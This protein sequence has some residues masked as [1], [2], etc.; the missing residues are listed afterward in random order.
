M[1]TAYTGTHNMAD[2]DPMA[3]LN[4]QRSK[5]AAMQ[6]AAAEQAQ[7]IISERTKEFFMW[8]RSLDSVDLIR[9]YRN[10]VQTTKA[11]LVDRALS[12]LNTGKSA[13]KVILELAN[14]L[15]NRLMHAPTRAI[16]DAAKKGE[17]AQ[18]N[19]LKKM[20]GIDQE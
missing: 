9:H 1:Y 6:Q 8:L 10:D 13:E 16:Q 19:Q 4:A 5:L 17:V 20:L 3:F 11:E 12:Q 7:I 15:T 2:E 18:L 14:K